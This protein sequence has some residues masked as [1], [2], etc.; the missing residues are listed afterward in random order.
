MNNPD[1]KIALVNAI[2]ELSIKISSFNII[3][4]F[5]E[6]SSHTTGLSIRVMK[7]GWNA[8]NPVTDYMRT[9][10]LDWDNSEN[11]LQEVLEYLETLKEEN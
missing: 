6:Y 2:T 3:D 1:K 8:D 9:V 5:V 11:D 10:Y 4:I 7:D